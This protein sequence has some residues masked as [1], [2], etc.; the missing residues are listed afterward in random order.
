MFLQQ[1]PVLSDP[2]R[3]RICTSV[4]VTA[5]LASA[6]ILDKRHRSSIDAD[7]ERAPRGCQF[8]A[9]NTAGRFPFHTYAKSAF[10]IQATPAILSGQ[11]GSPCMPQA[12]R[13]LRVPRIQCCHL[14]TRRT[15]DSPQLTTL[16]LRLPRLLLTLATPQLARERCRVGMPS[17][18]RAVQTWHETTGV[19][20][21][22]PSL[23]PSH[24]VTLLQARPQVCATDRQSRMTAAVGHPRGTT[25]RGRPRSS[26]VEV[27]GH[28]CGRTPARGATSDSVPATRVSGP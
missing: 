17:H 21:W 10:P 25:S 22:T 27:P 4:N 26:R 15:A 6:H 23:K 7:L 13:W 5:K 9:L 8:G 14:D 16:H 1:P 18:Q 19:A 20:A 12:F 11:A 2:L 3:K 24:V 28:T